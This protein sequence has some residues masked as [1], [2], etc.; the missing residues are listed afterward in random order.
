[1]VGESGSGKSVTFLALTGL[2]AVR[3]A[4]VSGRALFAGEDLLTMAPDRLRRLRGDRIGMVFQDPATALNPM[5]RVGDQIAEAVR[6]HRRV[7]RREAGRHAEE[8]LRRVGVPAPEQRARQY[9]HE[10]SGGMR[11]RAAI[12]M[13]LAPDPDLLIADEP[14]TA[15]DVTVQ[16]QILELLDEIRRGAGTAVVLIS[17]SLPTVAE[18]A[19]DVMVMYA[20]RPVETGSCAEVLGRPRHPYTRAL[21]G[22]APPADRR[23]DRLQPVEGAPPSPADLPPGCAFHPRCPD[24]VAACTSERPEPA[25]DGGTHTWACHV[26]AV[27]PLPAGGRVAA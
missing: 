22:A 7:G 11:Q 21:L 2:L 5:H 17:H 8:A 6:A 14:T 26:P 12:A 18:V 16:A 3:G 1:V 10:F 23:V 13:A 9:P 25:G 24:R 20:G 4:R 15:L 19:Q 27:A